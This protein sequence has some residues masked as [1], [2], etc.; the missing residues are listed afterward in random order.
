MPESATAALPPAEDPD[1][2]RAD[3]VAHEAAPG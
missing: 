1:P 2:P 3:G